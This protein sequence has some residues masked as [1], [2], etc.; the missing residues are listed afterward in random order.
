M[1]IPLLK[2]DAE[3][4]AYDSFVHGSLQC[5]P[6]RALNRRII[7]PTVAPDLYIL[8]SRKQRSSVLRIRAGRGRRYDLG[9]RPQPGQGRSALPTAIAPTP[10]AGA[11]WAGSGGAWWSPGPF[12]VR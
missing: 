2:M 8:S 3:R 5:F 10:G 6:E 7:S 12:R 4:R 1:S 11:N 9:Y